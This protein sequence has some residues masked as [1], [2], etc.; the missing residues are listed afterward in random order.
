MVDSVAKG[1]PADDAGFRE[2]D[3]IYEMDGVHIENMSDYES[4]L[5]SKKPNDKIKVLIYRVTRNE[6]KKTELEVEI[7]DSR[8]LK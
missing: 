3:I 4:F 8:G 6:G 2:G 7:G 5:V 1:S